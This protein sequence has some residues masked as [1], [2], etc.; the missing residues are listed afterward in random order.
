MSSP[1]VKIATNQR[2][3]CIRCG[4]CCRRWHVALSDRDIETLRKLRWRPQ[5]EIPE[6]P[7]NLINGHPFVAH[8][9]NGDCAYLDPATSLCRIHQKHG[10]AAK[11]LGCRVYPF[12]LT[13]TYWSE[14]S[15]T[16]RM[17]CPAVQQNTGPPLQQNR[18]D[19][20]KYAGLLG[21]KG[22]YTDELEDLGPAS[23]A[24]MTKALKEELAERAGLAPGIRSLALLIAAERCQQL[25]VDFLNDTAT[26][27]EIIP[28]FVKRVLEKALEDPGKPVRAWSRAFFRVWLATHLR[29]DEE[30]IR[31][32]LADRV[33]RTWMLCRICAG[34][35]SFGP[36]GS[37]HPD[38]PLS[39]ADLFPGPDR[40]AAQALPA[41]DG[42]KGADRP[43]QSSIQRDKVDAAAGAGSSREEVWECYWRFLGARLETLQ[44]FGVSFYGGLFYTGLRALILTYPMVLAAARCR[45]ASRGSGEIAAEDVQ[46]A[47]GAVDHSFGRSRLLQMPVWRSVEAYFSGPRYGRLLKA[48]GWQ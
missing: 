44:F 27:E 38:V 4:Q 8:K 20:E 34:R 31:K 5:D 29:R 2:F 24:L 21:I 9:P 10:A 18:R 37:E 23:V 11:P 6:A 40:D 32:G 1:K 42:G 45:A 48:M 47:V 36:L 7:S 14:I 39:Q 12:N 19:V 35:G 22:G 46:Y 33:G 15:V 30:M 28:S 43:P 41:R 17:D 3:S 16:A 13:S 26:L 25:G